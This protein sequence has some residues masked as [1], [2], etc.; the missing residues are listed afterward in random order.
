[1]PRPPIRD[2]G[3]R[4]SNRRG[5][6]FKWRHAGTTS[7]GALPAVRVHRGPSPR[8]PDAGRRARV[9]LAM[10][11][12]LA[13][14]AAAGA[15]SVEPLSLDQALGLAFKANPKLGNAELEVQKSA[16]GVAA[17]KTQYLPALNLSVLN[18]RN[19]TAQSFTYETGAFGTYPIIGPIPATTTQIGS[20]SG[21]TSAIVASVSQPLLQLYR[22][23]LVVDQ[24]VVMQSMAEQELRAQ[25]QDL[26]KEVKQ[27]YY[28]I[29]KT[30]S[31]LEATQESI[32][33]LRELAALVKRYVD[34]KVALAY[35]DLEVR[36]RLAK[37]EHKSRTERNA[38]LTEMERLNSLM[39]REVGTRFRTSAVGAVDTA[40][41]APAKAEADALAQRPEIQQA[42]LKLQHAE[43]GYQIKKSEYI[44]DL[45]LVMNYSRLHNVQFIP[46]EV[47]TVGLELRWQ[48]YDWG[49]TDDQLGQKTADIQQARNDIRAKEAQVKIEVDAHLRQLEEA[50]EYIGVA[51]L[52]QAASRE[53][54]R[55]LMNRYREQATLLTDVLQAES[56]LADAN[57]D[58]Q[59]AL[60]SLFAAKAQL[61]KALGEE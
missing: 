44:P 61:D 56:E 47:W 18:S 15:E 58:Y 40:G 22:T 38:L 39:G 54:L 28:E 41:R 31:A 24:H 2:S 25:R 23:G 59:K 13:C 10:L 35:Q 20:Q 60:L 51:E 17:A 9:L 21:V 46:N 43:Y 6:L 42:R 48:I 30:Q 29:L 33:F 53:K 34:E 27:Q 8:P 1:M 11:G 55:V 49:R 37:V 12:V 14:G 57:S 45:N 5:F 7:G 52:A 26:V 4:F 3:H 32:A 50:K 19:L 16:D 36:S